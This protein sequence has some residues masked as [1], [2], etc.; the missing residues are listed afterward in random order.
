[1]KARIGL[2]FYCPRGKNWTVYCYDRVTETGD[3]AY[4]VE[5]FFTK[6]EASAFVYEKNSWNKR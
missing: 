4:K 5:T 1:M 3:S 6:T 2:Y